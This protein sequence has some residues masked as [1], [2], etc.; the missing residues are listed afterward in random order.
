LVADTALVKRELGWT[1]A[2]GIDAIIADA[3]AWHGEVEAGV[4]PA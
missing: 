1:P 2:R 3:W 4:F